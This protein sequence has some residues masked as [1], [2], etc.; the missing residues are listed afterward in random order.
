VKGS[1]SYLSPEQ[2]RGE[3]LTG[4]SDLFSA[5][6]VLYEL[7]TGTRLF[8][9]DSDTSTMYKVLHHVPAPP[10]EVVPDIGEA[11][12]DMVMK[13][14]EKD[15]ANRF[16]SGRD[17]AKAIEAAAG[18]RTFQEDQ[19]ARWMRES[20]ATAI[21][22]TQEMFRLAGDVD[23][24][25]VARAARRLY[26]HLIGEHTPRPAAEAPPTRT[27]AE[28]PIRPGTLL[29]VDDSQVGRMLVER[30]LDHDG[31]RIVT[32]ASGKDAL[33][34]LAQLV[35]D[36]IIL[37]INMPE[38]DGLELCSRIRAIESLRATPVIFLSAQCSLAERQRGIEVGGDDFLR[39]PY[40]AE[41]LSAMVRRHLR[42]TQLATMS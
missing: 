28:P 30:M 6:I 24:E 2:V 40:Q 8:H 9:T 7:L 38:M 18:E 16:E 17:M 1:I 39:K 42:R 41:E 22:R 36:A 25:K 13:A 33:E 3:E 37:D 35:P 26:H 27:I 15:P 12:S 32:A 4:R 10:R 19:S 5:G 21:E 20:F 14:L 11:L 23:P 34:I 31:H 29:V